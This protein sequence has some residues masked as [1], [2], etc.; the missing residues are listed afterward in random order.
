MPKTNFIPRIINFEP[1]DYQV[2]RQFAEQK[3]LGKK[4][5]SAALR[6]IIREWHTS[7][8]VRLRQD[9]DINPSSL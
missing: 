2:V 5:F 1:M 3:R 6:T 9:N 8:M 7:R 4:G